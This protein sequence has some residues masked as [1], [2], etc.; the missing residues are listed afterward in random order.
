[1][2]AADIRSLLYIATVTVWVVVLALAFT[3]V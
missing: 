3:L 1:M 2:S